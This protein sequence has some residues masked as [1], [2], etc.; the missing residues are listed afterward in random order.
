MTATSAQRGKANRYKGA[1]AERDLV[2]WLRAHGWPNAERSIAT[3]HRSG[4]RVRADW[5]DVIGTPGLVWQVKNV[6]RPDIDAWLAETEEQ[7][8]AAGADHGLLVQRRRGIPDPDRWWV[9][10]YGSAFAE[11]FAGRIDPLDDC[12][13]RIT[14]G[15]LVPYLHDAGYGLPDNEEVTS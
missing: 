8:F 9:H 14:L 12:T 5:G 4:D 7:R 10:L 11:I 15:S 3:G 13:V 1:Q 2:R 6:Q